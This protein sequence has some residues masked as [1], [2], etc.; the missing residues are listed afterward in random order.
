MEER[1][2]D[3]RLVKV[4]IEIDNKNQL[5]FSSKTAQYNYFNSCTHIDLDDS[6]YQRKDSTVRYP[7]HID[8]LIG[9]NYCMYRN[10]QYSDKWFYAFIT[11]MRYMNDEMTLV[12]IKT[13]VWQTWWDDIEIKKCFVEREHVNDDTVGLHTIPEQ[14]ETGEYISSGLETLY[15]DNE[16]YI[17][18]SC[19]DL[20]GNMGKSTALVYNGVYSGTDSLLFDSAQGATNFIEAM[21]ND[22][23]DLAGAIVSIYIVPT[24]IFSGQTLNWQ[25]LTVND[26]TFRTARVPTS[27]MSNL[28]NTSNSIT[29]PSSI[30]GYSPKNN[31]LKV[32]PYSY[33]YVTNNNG[34]NATFKYEDFVN[35]TAQFKTYGS[36]TPGC[37][38][39]TVPINYKKMSDSA[40]TLKS[41]EY[42]INAGKFPVCSWNN[43]TYT[44]WLTSNTVNIGFKTVGGIV[45]VVGG[46]ALMATG[47]GA[48]V[49]ASMAAGGVGLITDTIRDVYQH[50]LAADQASGNTNSGDVCFSSAMNKVVAYKMNIRSEFAQVIDE[51]FSCYGYKVCRVKLPNITGRTN[52]NFVKTIDCNIHGFIPQ[53]DCIEIKNMFNA[54]VTFWH[55]PS[56]FLDYSQSNTIVS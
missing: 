51:Y 19:A 12:T 29:V 35:N 21:D 6:S 36:L 14:L 54:G 5:T 9:Y 23:K 18:I 55:N 1:Y 40:S 17:C 41:Y 34:G 16:W 3:V 10:T 31:K 52:W 53:K 39:R 43:D 2:T 4:P 8:D 7:G 11:D 42:G 49:G 22:D 56:T 13:D 48:G 26:K 33:L 30:D 20:P 15:F 38:I 45:G 28:L 47:A 24:S 37:S 46:V 25:T 50:S 32:F 44:N 27:N